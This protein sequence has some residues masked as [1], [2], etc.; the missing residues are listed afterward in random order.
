MRRAPL[1]K[2]RRKSIFGPGLKQ[3]VIPEEEDETSDHEEHRKS[4]EPTKNG[5]TSMMQQPQASN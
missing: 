1:G 4:P 5:N 3:S 2:A